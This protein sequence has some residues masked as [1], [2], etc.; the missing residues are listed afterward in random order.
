MMSYLENNF[1]IRILTPCRKV[2]IKAAIV[3]LWT[4]GQLHLGQVKVDELQDLITY[5]GWV[6]VKG[7]LSTAPQS[8]VKV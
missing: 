3:L 4:L 5:I 8:F 6:P 1:L 7:E 2:W